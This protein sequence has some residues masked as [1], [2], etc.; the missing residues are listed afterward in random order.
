MAKMLTPLRMTAVALI[1]TASIGVSA[2]ARW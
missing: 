2:S 1:A